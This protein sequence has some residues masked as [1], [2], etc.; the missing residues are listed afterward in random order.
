[1]LLILS[2]ILDVNECVRA[3]ELGERILGRP[4]FCLLKSCVRERESERVI[5]EDL[6]SFYCE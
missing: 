5:K 4:V 3:E 6:Y 1:M 2:S